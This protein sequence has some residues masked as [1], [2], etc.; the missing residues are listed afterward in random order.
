M[1]KMFTI[2]TS[3]FKLKCI[4]RDLHHYNYLMKID[5]G[6]EEIQQMIREEYDKTE[7]AYEYHRNY[8]IRGRLPLKRKVC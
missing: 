4:E 8:I 3:E 7:V 6:D 5:W 1:F 2:N